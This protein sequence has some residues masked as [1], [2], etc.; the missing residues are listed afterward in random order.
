MKRDTKEARFIFCIV[1]RIRFLK[2]LETTKL[3][4]KK[5]FKNRKKR[6]LWGTITNLEFTK[7]F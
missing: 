4:I 2:V 3:C 7:I 1:S 6:N 5:R